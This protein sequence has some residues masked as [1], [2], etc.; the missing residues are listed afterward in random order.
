MPVAIDA[1]TTYVASYHTES[2][3][4]AQDVGYFNGD[5]R[6]S[7]LTALGEGIDGNNGVFG[8]GA[9]RFPDESFNGSNYWVDVVFLPRE[10]LDQNGPQVLHVMPADGAS[11]VALDA[12]VSI[13]FNE[14]LDPTT[15]NGLTFMLTD[16]AGQPVTTTV[17]LNYDARLAILTPVQPLAFGTTYNATIRGGMAEPTVKDSS[18]NA[19]AADYVW[20]FTTPDPPPIPPN[21]G[22]GGPIL[23]IT[24]SANPF[25]RY[26]NEI[27]RA[28]GLNLFLSMDISLVDATVLNNYEVVIL[29][30]MALTGSQ[31]TML[32]D[33]VN[34]GGKLIA[35][36][37]DRQLLN[38]LGLSDSGGTL[39][40]GY[41]L[42]DTSRA[43]GQGIVAET[44]Q[45]H[46]IADLY[47]LAGANSVATLYSDANTPYGNAPAVTW[48]QVGP[49]GGQAAAF[50]YDLARSIVYMRQGN[51]AWA[52]QERD[53]LLPIR[54]GDMFYGNAAGDPQPDWIDLNKVA[55]PQADEQQRLLANLILAMNSDGTPLPRFWYFPSGQ[56]AVVVMTGDDHGVGLTRDH[57]DAFAAMSP[58]NCSVD[59]W[60]CVR[61]T[62]YIY[63]GTLNDAEAA[64]YEAAGFEVALHV[65]SDCNNFD[66][67]TLDADFSSQLASFAATYSSLAAPVTNRTHCAAWSDWSTQ[68]TVSARYDVRLDTNY[69]YFPGSWVANRMGFFTGFRPAHA[70]CR[71]GGQPHRCIP[72]GDP[73]YRRGG[74]GATGQRHHL[75]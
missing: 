45:Y 25:T 16:E 34:G 30:E 71:P 17:N 36:R 11:D 41:L 8:Y 60:Q 23:V 43:P 1:D 66:E 74:S 75:A 29:G 39:V 56:K 26:Y 5:V 3:F 69:Y 54:S 22:P 18:G 70:L 7:P 32:T 53:G 44:M 52:G 62:S 9:S 67:A 28:E 33:W 6:N 37:P 49:N 42:V 57:F 10:T 40:E 61:G 20:S 68:A 46:G 12:T 48:R 55:I 38:L 27:L 4:Y 47:D 59:D 63:V 31:V 15:V 51:P 73:A 13:Q 64:A 2:G 21:D 19:L 24:A 14:L 65:S 58:V 50:T 35:M 72:G